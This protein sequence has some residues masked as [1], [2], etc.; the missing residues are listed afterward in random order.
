MRIKMK[1]L[2]AGPGGVFRTGQI[3]DLSDSQAQD[4]IRAG[5]AEAIR[6]PMIEPP[7]ILSKPEIEVT[8][9]VIN[10]EKTSVQPEVKRGPG[11]PPKNGA[12]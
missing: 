12:V 4:F 2:A 11:R 7:K 10:M 1:T 9:P 3:V 6:I 8:D 5:A